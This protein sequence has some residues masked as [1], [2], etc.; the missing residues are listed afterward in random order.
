MN[1]D[2]LDKIFKDEINALDSVP[3]Q[4]GWNRDKTWEKLNSRLH[5]VHPQRKILGLLISA[6]SLNQWSY[7]IAAAVTLL[8]TVGVVYN[9]SIFSQITTQANQNNNE[10]KVLEAKSYDNNPVNEKLPVLSAQGL[11][12]QKG[13]S[14]TQGEPLVLGN[15]SAFTPYLNLIDANNEAFI[16]QSNFNLKAI[17]NLLTLSNM[18]DFIELTNDKEAQPLVWQEILP[19]VGLK[20]NVKKKRAQFGIDVQSHL[21][22]VKHNLA[23]GINVQWDMPLGSRRQL[24]DQVI[25]IGVD[26]QYQFLSLLPEGNDHIEGDNNHESAQGI[27][28]FAT[29]GYRRNFS[30]REDKPFWL[31]VKAGYLVQN[32]TPVFEDKTIKLEL[33]LGDNENNKFTISPQVYLT[34]NFSKVIPGIKIGMNLNAH[35]ENKDIAI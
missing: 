17:P 28:T 2:Q 13:N 12:A 29:V 22:L 14:F 5:E 19:V 3:P 35:Q 34:D 21:S 32:T 33:T 1:Y 30:K 9:Q 7:G 16:Y 4:V 20:E 11:L 31:G 8:I 26:N 15:G 25:S 6:G 27:N 18:Q 10:N 23:A 24:A